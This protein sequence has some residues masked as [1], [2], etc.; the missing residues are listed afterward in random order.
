MRARTAAATTATTLLGSAAAIAVAG[1]RG[2]RTALR[3]PA[4]DAV[5]A[6][7]RGGGL[8]VLAADDRHI[9]FTRTPDPVPPGRY[10]VTWASGR[11]ELGPPEP[12]TGT[13]GTPRRRLLRTVGG[14][15]APGTRLTL[16]PQLHT[17][18]PRTALGIDFADTAVPSELGPLPAW[19]V[20]GA[21][22]LWVIA[23]HGLG[24]TR[25][26]ALNL[27]PFLTELGL[28]VLV[29]AYRGDPGTRT[30]PDRLSRLGATEW[31]DADAALRHAAAYGARRVLLLGWSVGATM[32]LY[33]AARS[34]LHG[35][36]AGLVL[37]SPV[38]HRAT[39]VRALAAERGV[40]RPLLPLAVAAAEGAAGHDAAPDLPRRTSG[41]PLPTLIAHGPDDRIAP[42]EPSRALAARHPEAVSTYVARRAGHAAV[43]NADPASYEEELRRFVTPLL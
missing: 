43:W 3:P 11:A 7:F 30:A 4:R 9:T 2:G 12:D 19:F 36:I 29:P 15:P 16:T 31:R 40:R 20:P 13:D 33:T 28:P 26:Y 24:S 21:R 41:A 27:L 10:A 34:P 5:P 39:T 25:S 37:D 14:P 18:D 8:T 32:A 42:W 38:L 35:R 6:G 17:G 1:R 23:L 22:D